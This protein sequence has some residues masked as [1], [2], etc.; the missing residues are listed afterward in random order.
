MLLLLSTQ[1]IF[2]LVRFFFGDAGALL[3]ES[4][5]FLYRRSSVSSINFIK[6]SFS[7]SM[8]RF[9]PPLAVL[10]PHNSNVVYALISELFCVL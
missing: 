10:A 3:R 1:I 7:S 6:L 2:I 5:T 4:Y 9:I 8:N